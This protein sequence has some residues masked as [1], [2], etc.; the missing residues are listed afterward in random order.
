MNPD[1]ERNPDAYITAAEFYRHML[2]L[3]RRISRLEMIFYVNLVV[4]IA[5]L[6][7]LLLAP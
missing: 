6:L 2:K 7:K 3:E 4:T 5:T 1:S